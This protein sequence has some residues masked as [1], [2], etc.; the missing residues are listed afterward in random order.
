ME[1]FN[2]K[3][4]IKPTTQSKRTKVLLVCVFN[5]NSSLLTHDIFYNSFSR[6]GI[7]EKVKIKKYNN[8]FLNFQILIFDKSRIWK[9]FIEMSSEIEAEIAK[10]NLDNTMLLDDGSKMNVYFSNLPSVKFSSSN[11]GGV[12]K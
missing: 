9:T 2:S 7:V 5:K 3:F 8:E 12:G 6:F 11:S 1:I 10:E 4:Q